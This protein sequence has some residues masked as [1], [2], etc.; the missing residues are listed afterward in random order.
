MR[1][2]CRS[3]FFQVVQV[4]TDRRFG[5]FELHVD[6][7]RLLRDDA[8]VSLTPKEFDLLRLFL[9]RPGRALTRE[10]I[11]RMVW[12]VNVF[13]TTRSVDRCVTTLRKKIEA[14]PARP[15]FIQTIMEVGY[16]FESGD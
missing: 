5:N 9:N 4:S 3:D 6:S 13:V 12:G 15:T 11:L 14:D 1:T 10:E 16:R 2:L 8:E 7:H